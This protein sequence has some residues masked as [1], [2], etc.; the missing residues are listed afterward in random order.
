MLR[1]ESFGQDCLGNITGYRVVR[2]FGAEKEIV[3][4]FIGNIYEPGS[5]DRAREGAE[6]VMRRVN[7][8]VE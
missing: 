4:A 3:Q 8:G 7:E 1:I 6:E 2:Y 5:F